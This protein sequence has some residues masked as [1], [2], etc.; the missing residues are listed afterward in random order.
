MF[1][2]GKAMSMADTVMLVDTLERLGIDSHFREEIDTALCRLH[3]EKL[4]S[5]LHYAENY[6]QERT[7]D[8]LGK[9]KM[10]VA[11]SVECY[12]KEH[13]TTAEEAV[14]AI[15]EMVEQAWRRING[16]SMEMN[17]TLQLAA[18]RLVD[19][20]RILEIYYLRGRDG[21]TYGRDLK[22]LIT[23][24]FLQHILV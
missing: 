20:T 14:A 8:M 23:F 3:N 22:E 18:Q 4:E 21:L 16:A 12:M 2:L 19:M 11:S 7:F 15:A 24:I 6:L 13:G 1:E 17:R 10:D 5:E 9:N